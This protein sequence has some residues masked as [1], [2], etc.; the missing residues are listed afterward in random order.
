M[1]TSETIPYQL[2]AMRKREEFVKTY[3]STVLGQSLILGL[4]T[5]TGILSARMLGPV[6]RG[7][8]AAVIIWPTGI[9]TLLSLGINQAVAFNVGR[10]FFTISEITTGAAT[11]GLIQS[12]LSIIVGLAVIP[13]ALAKYSPAVQHLGIVFVLLTPALILGVYTSNLF[14]GEQDLLLFNLIRVTA[15]LTYASGLAGLYFAHRGN[16]SAVVFFT[17]AGYVA[18]LALGSVMMWSILRPRLE[19]N[20]SII[21]RLI[22]FGCRTQATSLTNYFNQRIDQMALSLFVPPRQL[23]FY[24]VAVTLA[25]AVTVFPQAAGIVTFSRGSSQNSDDAKKTIGISFRASLTWLLLCAS[26]LYLLAPFL[27]RLVFGSAFEGS[28]LACR[29]LLPG[30]VMIGLN[31]VLYNGSSAL[32]RPGLPSIA[33]GISMVV[34]AI[35]LY[36]LLPRYGFIG[37]AIISSIAYTTSFLLMLVLAHNQLGLSLRTLLVGGELTPEPF[38]KLHS[39]NYIER[40]VVPTK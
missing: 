25:T 14:Q 27:I 15:P 13:F 35:G 36:L 21:P 30:T 2:P 24:A 33:E 20:A 26:A 37:A 29:I 34:T 38:A 7:E 3:A 4:G 40:S 28:I 1:S 31:Q 16:L 17:L 6:G 9:A 23:G 18:A 22:H 19:W 10:G 39:N 11:I 5:L 32:G 12:A 8:Y